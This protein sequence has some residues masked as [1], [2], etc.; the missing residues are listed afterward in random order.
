MQQL[1]DSVRIQ[2]RVTEVATDKKVKKTHSHKDEPCWFWIHMTQTLLWSCHNKLKMSNGDTAHCPCMKEP[3]EVWLTVSSVENLNVAKIKTT[4]GLIQQEVICY[5][6]T[7]R[8]CIHGYLSMTLFVSC[9]KHRCE[10]QPFHWKV[11]LALSDEESELCLLWPW[12]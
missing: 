3:T 8:G 4:L 1:R 9:S 10:M 7:E 6:A 11:S 5:C 2:K 12:E